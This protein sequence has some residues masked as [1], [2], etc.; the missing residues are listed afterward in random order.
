M[1]GQMYQE[2]CF[3]EHGKREIVENQMVLLLAHPTPAMLPIKTI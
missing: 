3:V 1:N 2:V